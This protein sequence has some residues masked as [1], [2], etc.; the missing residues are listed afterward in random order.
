MKFPCVL[1][2]SHRNKKSA[3]I[4]TEKKKFWSE[5][6]EYLLAELR[7]APYTAAGS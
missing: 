4:S 6:S 3:K 1:N 2:T 7:G 5:E